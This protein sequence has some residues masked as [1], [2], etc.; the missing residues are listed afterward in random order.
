MQV[1]TIQ[2]KD[3]L[4][5]CRG[6]WKEIQFLQQ[7]HEAKQTKEDIIHNYKA[8]PKQMPP[9]EN[10]N[11]GLNYIFSSNLTSKKKNMDDKFGIGIPA[12][13]YSPCQFHYF[14]SCQDKSY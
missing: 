5:S 9:T 3:Y 10:C 4:V 7:E 13:G 12:H 8:K 11:N 1:T 14:A 6:V 2:V